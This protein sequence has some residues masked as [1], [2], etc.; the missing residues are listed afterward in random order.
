MR[1]AIQNREEI[2][3]GVD[4]HI[5]SLY[6]IL[7]EM[8][9]FENRRNI[10]NFMGYTIIENFDPLCDMCQKE[11]PTADLVLVLQS[12]K[13]RVTRMLSSHFMNV[14]VTQHFNPFMG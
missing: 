13:S 2:S 11:R 12:V 3:K 6:Q 10:S 1:F 14:L 7:V 8:L 9:K 4:R 5:P